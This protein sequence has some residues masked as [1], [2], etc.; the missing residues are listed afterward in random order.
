MNQEKIGKFIFTLRKEKN[1]TQQELADKIGVTDRAISKWENGRGMPDLS[2]MKPLCEELGITINELISG[3]R[4]SK[5]DYQVKLEETVFNTINYSNKKIKKT[6]KIFKTIISGFLILIS[7][8]IM[9]FIIDVKRMNDNK[10]VIFSTWG[11]KYAPPIDLYEDEIYLSIKN[12]LTFKGDSEVKN[13]LTEKTFVSMQTYLLE[14]KIKNKKYYVYAWVLSGKY[15][16][17]DEEIK[18]DSISSI[19]YKFVVEKSDGKFIVTDTLM[20]REGSLYTTDMKN[21]FPR[22]VRDDFEKC[23]ID[24]T[25]EKLQMKITEQ[26]KLYFHK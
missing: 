6:N 13:H 18:Q 26:T 17:E 1:F 2:L 11:F 8:L 14:E 12:Y 22:S 25:I 21:I 7:L 9:M 24:G 15:F 23:Q 5:D 4:I 16:I 3:E 19:P 20:P 10:P